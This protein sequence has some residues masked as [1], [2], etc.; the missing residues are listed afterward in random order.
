MPKQYK[1]YLCNKITAIPTICWH[2]D[3]DGREF[4]VKMKEI[5]GTYLMAPKEGC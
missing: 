5:P 2:K 4:G 1:C 3:K